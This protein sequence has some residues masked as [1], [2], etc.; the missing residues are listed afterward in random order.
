MPKENVDKLNPEF[1]E[2]FKFYDLNRTFHLLN[3]P[4]YL[5]SGI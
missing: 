5:T 4:G 3:I 2:S 1:S